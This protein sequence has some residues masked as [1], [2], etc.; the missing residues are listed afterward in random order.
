MNAPQDEDFTGLTATKSQ[1]STP[2][3][4]PPRVCSAVF[5]A[6]KLALKKEPNETAFETAESS[7]MYASRECDGKSHTPLLFYAPFL[8]YA[9]TSKKRGSSCGGFSGFC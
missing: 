3:F 8:L 7:L 9:R 4:P 5:S 6:V 1:V 2:S